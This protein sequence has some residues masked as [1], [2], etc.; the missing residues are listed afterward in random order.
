MNE[1]KYIYQ[2]DVCQ[3]NIYLIILL[4]GMVIYISMII[5]QASMLLNDQCAINIRKFREQTKVE[6]FFDVFTFNAMI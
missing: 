3:N 1:R 6:N 5:Y 2:Y 4:K